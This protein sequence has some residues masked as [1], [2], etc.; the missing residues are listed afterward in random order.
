MFIHI[1]LDVRKK[2]N[3]DDLQNIF[4]RRKVVDKSW[5]AFCDL[6]DNVFLGFL[7][8]F[9]K[10]KWVGPRFFSFGFCF[11]KNMNVKKASLFL[12]PSHFSAR[13]TNRTGVNAE[14]P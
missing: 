12:L 8:T 14:M 13:S 7:C 9:S 1:I 6:I 10:G 4:L 5:L 2:K 3:L 11:E